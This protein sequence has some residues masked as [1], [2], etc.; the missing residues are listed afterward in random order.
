MG[1]RRVAWGW[2][3]ANRGIGGGWAAADQTGIDAVVL[4]PAVQ[5]NT[6]ADAVQ[7]GIRIIV[8]VRDGIFRTEG[9]KAG[10]QREAHAVLAGGQAA[11]DVVAIG[12]GGARS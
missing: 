12:I 11:E 9:G 4:F 5:G 3:W 1:R 8:I 10:R 7:V 2:G 6:I